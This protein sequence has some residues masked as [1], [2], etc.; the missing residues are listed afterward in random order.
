MRAETES[1]QAWLAIGYRNANSW[2]LQVFS[3]QRPP[4][5]GICF[6][7]RNSLS[8]HNFRQTGSNFRLMGI[9]TDNG[10]KTGDPLVVRILWAEQADEAIDRLDNESAVLM[11]RRARAFRLYSRGHTMRRI[12]E[13]TESSTPTVCRD[14]R[15]VMEGFRKIVRQ[16]VDVQVSREL[17]RLAA[18]ELEAW[19][20][21]DRSKVEKVET[22]TSKSDHATAARVAKKQRDGDPRFLLV[23][24]KLWQNRCRLLGLLADNSKQSTT[25]PP[26]KLVAGVIPEEV[27]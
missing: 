3:Q 21:W 7:S 17:G 22:T 4:F 26:V 25:T 19:E 11:E 8:R 12:A 5:G 6:I 9:E 20:A 14:I 10:V 2:Q 13:M 16:D 24:E 23:L 1:T 27:V 15:E 18:L